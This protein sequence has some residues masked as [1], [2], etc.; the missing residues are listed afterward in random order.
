MGAPRLDVE[1]Y[2]EVITAWRDNG[3]S[4]VKGSNALK[5]EYS[6]FHNRLKVAKAMG[7][8][9][10]DGAK[11]VVERAALSY[12]EAK[13]G[14]I[15]DYNEDGRKVGTTRWAV[16]ETIANEDTLARI[17]ASFERLKPIGKITPPTIVN[18]D[19]CNV[20]PLYDVHWGMAA[21]GK[22]TGDQDY[23]IELAHDDMMMG[24]ESLLAAAP[25]AKRCVL[26]LGGDFL[27]ANDDNHQTPKSKHPLDVTGRMYDTLETAISLLKYVV[28]RTLQHH[29]EVV[30][31]VLRGN[32][33]EFS[34]LVLT[35]AL[36][37]W[38]SENDRA[39]VMMDPQEIFMMRWGRAA[40][41]G[42]H[43]DKMK[44]INLALKLSDICPFWSDCRHRYAY[45]GH[46]HTL[47][48][49]RIGGL[50]WERL[51]PF[52]PSDVYGASWVNRRAMKLDTYH[53]VRGRV[54]TFLDPLE[55]D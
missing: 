29:Q 41:F 4:L 17:K 43:G 40:I 49:E 2:Q 36:N 42:Q 27:H 52:A 19:L 22:E 51:E 14:W 8:H 3:N 1:L 30:I 24:L 7:L 35:F 55:R 25:Q 48:S 32:H 6:L 46:L 21:W 54:G 39:T 37:E 13:G 10:S 50:N 26:L 38:L 11:R 20:I 31:R 44:P 47:T 23:D 18:E 33:D 5:M 28:M 9:L 34:H 15:H 45:T 53:N 12:T 16:D